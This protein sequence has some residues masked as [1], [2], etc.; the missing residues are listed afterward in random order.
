MS[1]VALVV[2]INYYE[3]QQQLHGCVKDANSIA[4]LLKYHEN[5]NSNFEV[6]YLSANDKSRAI[7]SDTLLQEVKEFFDNKHNEV[8]LFYFSGHGGITTDNAGYLATSDTDCSDNAILMKD[9]I[10]IVNKSEVQNKIIILDTCHSGYMGKHPSYEEVG[11]CIGEGVTILT[12][13]SQEQKAKEN[14][15]TLNRHGVFTELLIDALEGGNASI[16]GQIT[17][18]SIYA[19]IDKALGSFGQRPIFKT[20]TN[21]FIEIRQVTPQIKLRELRELSNIF[22]DPK[23]EYSLDQTYEL[24]KDVPDT[25]SNKK[26]CIPEHNRIFRILQ[27]LN[28][29]NIIIPVGAKDMYYSAMNEKAC[30]LTPLGRFY[31]ELAKND[32]F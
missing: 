17:L 30:K 26:T 3:H 15:K 20:N 24:D 25:Y 27:N 14:D 7:T 21:R 2:G 8:A 23:I 11:S 9:L 16:I 18:G 19:H 10:E 13:S 29:V 5:D 31:W 1:K 4:E 22:S 32:R 28:R 6:K 12:A